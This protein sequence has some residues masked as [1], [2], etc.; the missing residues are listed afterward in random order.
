M[1]A[2]AD[3]LWR[4]PRGQE[5]LADLVGQPRVLLECL[6]KG[7]LRLA[8]RGQGRVLTSERRVE[9]PRR[10]YRDQASNEGVLELES[11]HQLHLPHQEERNDERANMARN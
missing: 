6:L 10:C 11:D 8:R 9:R 4:H 3:L 1:E 7:R 5:T 2:G